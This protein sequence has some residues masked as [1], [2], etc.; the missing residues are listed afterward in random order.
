MDGYLVLG[1]AELTLNGVVASGV[2]QTWVDADAIVVGFDT[3]D[4]LRNGLPHPGGCTGA[5]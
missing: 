1:I 2:G 4:E 3:E 5:P